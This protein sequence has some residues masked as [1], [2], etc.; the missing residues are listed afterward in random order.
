MS[1][2]PHVTM[3]YLTDLDQILHG[4]P[5]VNLLENLIFLQLCAKLVI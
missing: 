1:S 5:K 2:H 3:Q 4:A